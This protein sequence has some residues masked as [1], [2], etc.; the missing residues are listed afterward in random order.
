MVESRSHIAA[1]SPVMT[2]VSGVVGLKRKTVVSSA[3]GKQFEK[4]VARLA[5]FMRDVTL[6][7]AAS[8]YFER[9]VLACGGGRM[10]GK[11][12]VVDAI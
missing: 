11:Q 10:C 5:S 9:N 2:N 12:H 1:M 4:S 7:I 3:L 8:T 6:A